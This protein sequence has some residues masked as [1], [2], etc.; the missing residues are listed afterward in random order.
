MSALLAMLLASTV[1]VELTVKKPLYLVRG[2]LRG[3]I[4][5]R[6]T[7]SG[8]EPVTV[9]HRDVHGL[10]FASTAAEEPAHTVFHSCDCGF[11]L[12]LN[13]PPKA[14]TF[15]L[16][17]GESRV[18]KFDDFTC[19]G[20]PYRAPPEGRYLLS[21]SLHQPGA[22]AKREAF[23]LKRCEVVTSERPPGPFQS[24]PVP[25]ELKAKKK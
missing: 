12:G 4:E 14:R 22:P 20:G 13:E 21:Y 23:D 24:A 7:N 2:E 16:K 11:E 15:T 18:L 19:D 8:A 9:Q 17:A 10:R 3:V 1:D 5:V 25:L 6:V